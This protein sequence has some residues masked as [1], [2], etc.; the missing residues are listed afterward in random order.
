MELGCVHNAQEQAY[1]AL[2]CIFDKHEN[3]VLEIEI[4]PKAFTPV[5]GSLLLVDDLCIGIPKAVLIHAFLYARAI[6]S[7]RHEQEIDHDAHAA[8]TRTLSS[9]WTKVRAVLSLV[10]FV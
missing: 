5:D 6:F 8:F 7:R 4:L 1:N 10:R 2:N 9:S 3:E